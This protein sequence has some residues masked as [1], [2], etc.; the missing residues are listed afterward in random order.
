MK[1]QVDKIIKCIT[2]ARSISGGQ[3]FAFFEDKFRLYFLNMC[4]A[5]TCRFD[6]FNDPQIILKECAGF[7]RGFG[8]RRLW[9]LYM[10]CWFI[11]S[12]GS[13]F[14]GS[15][16]SLVRWF[17]FYRCQGFP[18]SQGSLVPRV[19]V[20]HPSAPSAFGFPVPEVPLVPLVLPAC[21]LVLWF[22][23]F[24]WFPWFLGWR[25]TLVLCWLL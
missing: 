12:F 21:L 22:L 1:I 25:I 2:I 5:S 3:G 4:N 16:G 7:M 23:W 15:P 6:W 11:W 10:S 9:N 18:G 13:R 19:S 24:H 20:V 14:P 8:I 17:F